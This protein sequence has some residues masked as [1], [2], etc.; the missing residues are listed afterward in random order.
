MKMQR[1]L[2]E[3]L[4]FLKKSYPEQNIW[5]TFLKTEKRVDYDN[6]IKIFN[7]III[8][9]IIEKVKYQLCDIVTMNKNDKKSC[10][11]L[12]YLIIKKSFIMILISFY[13]FMIKKIVLY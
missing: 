5:W 3:I 9:K 8:K 6:D 11:I 12:F 2:L 13:L 10:G 4:I 7:D 1:S